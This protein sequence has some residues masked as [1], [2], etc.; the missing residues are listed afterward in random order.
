VAAHS[1]GGVREPVERVWSIGG[2][3]SA[4]DGAEFSLAATLFEGSGVLLAAF[5]GFA[6]SPVARL[7]YPGPGF[8]RKELTCIEALFSK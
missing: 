2:F 6:D 3:V 8:E 7:R 4:H 5:H 1:H